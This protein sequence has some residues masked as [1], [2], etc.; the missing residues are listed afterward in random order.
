MA[1]GKVLPYLVVQFLHAYPRSLMLI[2]RPV[3]GVRIIERF[4]DWR[5]ICPD[6]T[7]A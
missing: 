5:A 2:K 1:V 3:W 6:L 7:A 4:R